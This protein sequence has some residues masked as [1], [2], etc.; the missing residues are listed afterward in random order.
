MAFSILGLE[1]VRERWEK[2][3][4]KSAMRLARCASRLLIGCLLWRTPR[5]SAVATHL[6]VGLAPLRLSRKPE[7]DV[8]KGRPGLRCPSSG[9]V[10]Q[11][12][13]LGLVE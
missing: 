2:C 12:P 1:A 4:P 13:G 3:E 7:L 9:A 11:G 5:G 10:G 6:Q 8:T